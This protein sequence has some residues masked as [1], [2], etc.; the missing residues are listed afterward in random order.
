MNPSIKHILLAEDDPRDAKLT[1]D[2]L[3]GNHVANKVFVVH[4]GEAVLDY[5]FCE[6]KYQGREGGNPVAL[7]L[8]LKM[9]KVDGLEVLKI[10]KAD[11]RLKSIPVIML[12]SSRET[13]D[14]ME[15]YA[16]GVNA[17]VVK[18]VDFH[19]FENAVNQL[20]I[21]WAAI[22]EP[23]PQEGA[24]APTISVEKTQFLTDMKI[25]K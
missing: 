20:G 15:C 12:T 11:D 13:P 10:I 21:F 19:E 17:Y 25:K 18:P 14:L 23:P 4:D 9:P 2:A 8:D 5:L 22:N 3:E 16:H 1:L 6:G 7:L 24:P